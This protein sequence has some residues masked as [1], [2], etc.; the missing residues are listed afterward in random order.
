MNL[1]IIICV[2][3]TPKNLFEGCL[4]S[5]KESTLFSESSKYETEI[6]M[7]DD[8]S[9]TDYSDLIDKYELKC[10]KTENCGIFRARALG[11][12]LAT[13]EYITFVD[14]DDTVSFNYHLPM[15]E[16]AKNGHADIVI[17]DWAYHT[18]SSRYYTDADSTLTTESMHLCGE[19]VITAFLSQEG[20]EHSY[21]VL[22]NKIYR[23][24]ILTKATERADG[25]SKSIERYN[26][27]EDAL[28]NFYAFLSADLVVNL[29]TGYYFYRIHSSQSVNVA[30]EKS[31][32]A[33]IS[34]MSFTLD[35]MDASLKDHPKSEILKKHVQ[36]WR[37]FISRS[38]F[39]HAK[40]GGFQNLYPY[41]MEKYG[42]KNLKKSTYRDEICGMRCVPLPDN[43]TEI[44]DALLT[45]WNNK[46]LPNLPKRKSG[47]MLR[48][49][50][51]FTKQ[52][53]EQSPDAPEI[54][55]PK[56]PF[57]KRLRFN[58]FLMRIARILF[59]KGS[60]I[61]SFLKKRM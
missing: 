9:D 59:P 15:I 52:G 26:Y 2:Y 17:N 10:T 20:R 50:D 16:K 32:R 11:V 4:R 60:K 25:E 36:K 19:D 58:A 53:F 23:K 6:I 48:T 40:S 18:D 3:N 51:Y 55:S 41:I 49:S 29:H 57:K 35:K 44:D 8:G 31:L 1:S 12:S 46:E 45:A 33:Q 27:S 54:P 22:W 28:I 5:I 38:H 24:E 42:V 7:I 21:Y 61:R 37:E 13:G 47:Y 30:S 56:I 14:S 34:L 43:F 39:T